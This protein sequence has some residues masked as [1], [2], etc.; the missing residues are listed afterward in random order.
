MSKTIQTTL[1]DELWINPTQVLVLVDSD[2]NVK[3]SG[4]ELLGFWDKKRRI[5]KIE[6]SLVTTPKNTID[7]FQISDL[8]RLGLNSK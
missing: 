2:G 7:I 8:N 5:S 6:D 3:S 4:G 1:A